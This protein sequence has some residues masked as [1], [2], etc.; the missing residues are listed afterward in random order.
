[1]TNGT[2][3]TSKT[4]K[5]GRALNRFDAMFGE[6]LTDV[7][8]KIDERGGFDVVHVGLLRDQLGHNHTKDSAER[9]ITFAIKQA[10]LAHLPE[11]IPHD[12]DARL[13]VYRPGAGFEALLDQLQR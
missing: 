2:R 8:R 6:A 10:G 3:Y 11:Q 4:N 9:A 1:M 7:V 13:L 12:Q 5:V